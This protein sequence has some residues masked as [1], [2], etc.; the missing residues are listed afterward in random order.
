[1]KLQLPELTEIQTD[2]WQTV[3]THFSKDGYII[4]GLTEKAELMEVEKF[5]LSYECIL[6]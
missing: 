3:H 2:M 1:M 4:P 6:R 5:W